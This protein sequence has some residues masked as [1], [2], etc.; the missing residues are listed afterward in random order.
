MMASPSPL[1]VDVDVVDDRPQPAGIA[2]C[3]RDRLG[4]RRVRGEDVSTVCV[5]GVGGGVALVV[6]PGDRH[7]VGVCRSRILVERTGEWC[8]SS[9]RLHRS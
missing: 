6:R 9:R 4:D 3:R 2:G 5:V 7:H 1:L 8:T